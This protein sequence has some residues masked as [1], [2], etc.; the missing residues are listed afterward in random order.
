MYLGSLGTR[1][2]FS[3][4]ASEAVSANPTYAATGIVYIRQVSQ[5]VNIIRLAS[6]VNHFGIPHHTLSVAVNVLLT[7]M[8]VIRLLLHGRKTRQAMGA[9][10]PAGG[11]YKI[12]ITVLTESC[13]LFAISFLLFIGFWAALNPLASAFF[14]IVVG[15]QVRSSFASICDLVA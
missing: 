4:R 15:T 3:Q 12:V 9:S 11:W 14:S 10:T 6:A 8:I 2:G 1:S 13:A 5:Q 7:L